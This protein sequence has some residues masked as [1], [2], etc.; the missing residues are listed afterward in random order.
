ML[1][2]LQNKDSKQ[3][4]EL[5]NTFQ[6]LLITFFSGKLFEIVQTNLN[7]D[8]RDKSDTHGKLNRTS[9]FSFDDK[10]AECEKLNC[11]HLIKEV[12][13]LLNLLMLHSLFFQV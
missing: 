12:I 10:I 11:T 4:P 5:K 3:K 7:F 6:N 1:K 2:T 13:F 8:S 9:K